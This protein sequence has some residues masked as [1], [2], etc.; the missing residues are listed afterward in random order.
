MLKNLFLKVLKLDIVLVLS[1]ILA[2]FSVVFTFDFNLVYQ[3][4]S[5]KTIF[6]LFIFMLSLKALEINGVFLYLANKS[7]RV[8]K[9]H[10]QLAF[11]LINITFFSS[12]L[13]TNDVALIVFVPFSLYLIKNINI[14]KALILSLQSI[15]ANLGSSFTPF[16]NPQNI[17]IYTFY[18]VDLFD[19]MDCMFLYVFVS[20][21][22]L[23]L[24][25]FVFF[26]N[27]KLALK[28]KDVFFHKNTYIYLVLFFV[29]IF[30]V[31]GFINLYVACIFVILVVLIKDF[32][33]FFLVDYGLLFT[34][35]FL[36][37]FVGLNGGYFVKFLLF[38]DMV[39]NA[40]FISNIISNVPA[41]LL[42]HSFE[43]D[44][45]VL[46]VGVN[47]GGLGTL[48]S[49]MAN[50]ITFKLIKNHINRFEF[51]KVFTFLNL[52]FLF[53][54]LSLYSFLH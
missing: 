8:L 42:L 11:S 44:F 7:L 49:S 17:F 14:N 5:F 10:K 21:L 43:S 3:S 12:M 6:L 20:F 19:F 37:V 47:I 38:F 2:F 30:A 39:Y 24:I 1:F 50:L 22:L 52:I 23:N 28:E 36:F 31:L 4:I 32:K 26:K 15:C 40:V 54:L 41:T 33:V 35:L 51:L 29:C 45:R 46:L 9:T 34:F 53:V 48:V 13:I 25:V 18:K 27:E 16:G